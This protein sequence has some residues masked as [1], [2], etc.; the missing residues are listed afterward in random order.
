MPVKFVNFLKSSLIFNTFYCFWMF[1]N[2][3]FTSHVR[4]CQKVKVFFN[5][6]SSIY[7]HT[8]TKILADSQV[9]ISVPLRIPKQ[10]YPL[11]FS[12]FFCSPVAILVQSNLSTGTKIINMLNFASVYSICFWTLYHGKS[13]QRIFRRTYRNTLY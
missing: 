5:V 10:K 6:K 4:V 3:L 9:C 12:N 11:K 1:V 13:L 7:F 2:K 8:K